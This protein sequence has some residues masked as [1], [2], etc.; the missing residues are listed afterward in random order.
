M[1]ALSV[2]H[3]MSMRKILTQR[4]LNK[5]SV[6]PKKGQHLKMVFLLPINQ[7]LW[8]WLQ[9]KKWF[10]GIHHPIIHYY[11]V[12]WNEERMLPWMF[13][14]YED[15]VEHFYIYDN[16]SND[17]S[18]EIVHM[19][20]HAELERYG[21]DESFDDWKHVQ[22]KDNCW[23]K[24]R[25]KADYVI[26]CDLDEFLYHPSLE[27][28]LKD[29]AKR[30]SSI[31]RI[32]GFE[33]V[34]DTY[35]TYKTGKQLIRIVKEGVAN[36]MMNKCILFDPHQIVEINYSLGAHRCQPCGRVKY[37]PETL[38]LL[39]YK[40]LGLDYVLERY[41]AYTPRIREK[42]KEMDV[43]WHYLFGDQKTTED[44]YNIFTQRNQVIP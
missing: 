37:H 36:P 44:F 20:K 43:G 32:E 18:K 35:P 25:G 22:I 42:N 41:H 6:I 29:A 2:S 7:V 12:C 9:I 19:H 3:N 23:K 17:H 5:L 24:S 16:C 13:A 31:F 39:H 14:H 28:V 4:I 34:T 15:W 26:V 40:K 33:M 21:S 11:A 10:R 27:T 8:I 1:V 30:H 38:S